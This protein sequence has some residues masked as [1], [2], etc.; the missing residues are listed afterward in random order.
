M[1]AEHRAHSAFGDL[2]SSGFTF[3][4]VLLSGFEI[5]LRLQAILLERIPFRTDSNVDADR[6][7][8]RWR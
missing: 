5:Q 1:I 8:D 7:G 4:W 3:E 2:H 6:L